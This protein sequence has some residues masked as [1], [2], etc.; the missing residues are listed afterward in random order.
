M[1]GAKAGA[2]E[3]E[4][5][6]NVDMEVDGSDSSLSRDGGDGED[7]GDGGDVGDGKYGSRRRGR[8]VRCVCCSRNQYELDRMHRSQWTQIH[9]VPCCF[10]SFWGDVYVGIAGGQ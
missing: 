1:Q 3:D 8:Y 5:K 7:G 6:D 9:L 4:D 10:T 2:G